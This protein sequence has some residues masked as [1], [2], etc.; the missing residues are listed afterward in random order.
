MVK[1]FLK[2]FLCIL[3]DAFAIIDIESPKF[4]GVYAVFLSETAPDTIVD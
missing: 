4:V 2:G 3:I 1:V